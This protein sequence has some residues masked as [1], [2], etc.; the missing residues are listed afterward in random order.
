[1]HNQ[2][3][4]LTICHHISTIIY[5]LSH[6]ILLEVTCILERLFSHLSAG[7]TAIPLLERLITHIS[8]L[9]T[10]RLPSKTPFRLSESY[11]LEYFHSSQNLSLSELEDRYLT[12]FLDS[13][14]T[15]DLS[16]PKRLPF[17]FS[18]GIMTQTGED[19]HSIIRVPFSILHF[20]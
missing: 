8:S 20:P 1:M 17:L 14:K 19:S 4:L 15:T 12:R 13:T 5:K 9:C 2:H 10:G 7:M 16:L 3:N 18:N 6:C 11:G